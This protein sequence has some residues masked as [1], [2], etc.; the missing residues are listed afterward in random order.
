MKNVEK[1]ECFAT[2]PPAGS[3]SPY[4]GDPDVFDMRNPEHMDLVIFG[5]PHLF[6][7]ATFRPRGNATSAEDW[8]IPLVYFQAFERSNLTP[9][10][11]M[12]RVAEIIQL[13]EPGPSPPLEPLVYVGLLSDVLCKAPLVPLYL[14]GSDYATIPHS[15]RSSKR[16]L[17][18]NGRADTSE[19]RGDGSRIYEVNKWLWNFGR[20][21]DRSISV[22]QAEM[23]RKERRSQQSARVWNS[24]KRNGSRRDDD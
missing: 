7:K 19:G 9:L 4:E 11:P 1:Q 24:R 5:R 16:R 20:G 10:H 21:I 18:P 6:F 17:F 14:E 8:T 23:I 3:P 13:Y 12:Q 2:I 22:F 15:F